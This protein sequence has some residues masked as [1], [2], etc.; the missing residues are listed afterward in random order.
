MCT[1]CYFYHHSLGSACDQ[2]SKTLIQITKATQANCPF[3]LRLKVCTYHYLN[4]ILIKQSLLKY[5][6]ARSVLI[7]KFP[8]FSSNGHVLLVTAYVGINAALTFTGVDLTSGGSLGNR[9][10]W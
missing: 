5:R 9:F 3:C 4:S 6:A 1:H 7:R 10:G 2:Q 8:G